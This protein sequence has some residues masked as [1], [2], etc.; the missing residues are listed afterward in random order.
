MNTANC[1]KPG[2]FRC[3]SFGDVHLGNPRTPTEFIIR[4]L[5]R[6]IN[7]DLIAQLD[8]LIIEGDLFDRLLDN[9]NA[10]T[11]RIH[12]WATELM[13]MCAKHN[14]LLRVLEGTPSHDWNQNVYFVEQQNNASIPVDLHYA[15]NLSIEYIEKFDIHVLYVPDKCLPH[16]D[17]IW[18]ETQVLL[19][20]H[21]LEKVDFAIMHG[22]FKYQL[23]DIVEEPTH[24]EQLYLDITK[25]FIFIGHVHQATQYERILAAGSFDRH[26]HGDE[27][28]KGFYDV[29]VKEDGTHRIV[30]VENKKAKRYD[31]LQCH[32]MDI[33]ELNVAVANKL[34]DLPK[35]SAI[36]LKCNRNDAAVSYVESLKREYIHYEWDPPLVETA[37]KK[38]KASVTDTLATFDMSEFLPINA[39]SLLGLL[40]GE[41]ERLAPDAPTV[42]RCM[43]HAGTILEV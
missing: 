5:Q 41:L 9:K 34:K 38:K 35:D 7:E 25:Y 31:T 1:K 24:V 11:Y 13:Y 42:E 10:D 30:F 23:P 20:K 40:Q 29:S 36:R 16:T 39:Q 37:D 22:A 27:G 4:N 43:K 14:T 33:K 21:N 6:Y 28:A 17:D 18:R 12:A 8:M 19:A 3:V 32:G 26:S 2:W 15:K